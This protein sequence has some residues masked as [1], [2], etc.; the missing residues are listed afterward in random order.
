MKK[1]A[2]AICVGAM[3]F[4][5]VPAFAAEVPVIPVSSQQESGITPYWTCINDIFTD[6]SIS[7]RTASIYADVTGTYG[8]ATKAKVV[9][10]LQEKNGSSWSTIATWTD[11]Q[12]DYR[13]S[14]S[15]TKS[16][17]KGKTYR[18][19]VTVTVWEGSQSES[20]TTYSGEETA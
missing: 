15:T 20:H 6:F 7:N 8:Q 16:V 2:A 1:A 14:V 9:V 13:A 5:A 11:T 10:E 12:N 18:I 4:T 17:T 3:A 19:K